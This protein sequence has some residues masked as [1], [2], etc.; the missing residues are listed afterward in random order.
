M[1]LIHIL[2]EMGKYVRKTRPKWTDDVMQDAARAVKSEFLNSLSDWSVQCAFSCVQRRFQCIHINMHF[3][4]CGA[5]T[6]FSCEKEKQLVDNY[7]MIELWISNCFNG[8]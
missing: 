2:K 3:Q 1:Y 4:K 6:V 8:C 5:E 7:K